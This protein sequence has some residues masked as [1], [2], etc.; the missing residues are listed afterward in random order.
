MAN[1]FAR[2]ERLKSKQ[3]ISDLFK[4]GKF[5]RKKFLALKFL[6]SNKSGVNQIAF[7]VPKR[8]FPKAVDRNRIKRRML[9]AYRLN[10]SLVL[11]SEG[12]NW[13]FILIYNT[14]K[15]YDFLEI[16]KILEQLF[17]ELNNHS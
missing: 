3:D 10:K 5:I 14:S 1:N 9:E 17:A 12:T 16:Q 13:H 15:E 11:A 6:P 8:R 4:E 7:S 2:N